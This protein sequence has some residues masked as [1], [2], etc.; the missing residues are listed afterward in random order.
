MSW[1]AYV[2]KTPPGA[3]EEGG[4]RETHSL[5]RLLR[6]PRDAGTV[7]VSWLPLSNL[8]AVRAGGL[9]VGWSNRVRRTLVLQKRSGIIRVFRLRYVWVHIGKRG[10]A[11]AWGLRYSIVERKTAGTE[12]FRV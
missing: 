2:D 6:L 12:A 10:G 8:Q 3:C 5:S 1:G 9:A 11:C 7:P 4:G